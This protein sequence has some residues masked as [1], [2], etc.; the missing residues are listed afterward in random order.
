MQIK[1]ID[2]AAARARAAPAPQ[3]CSNVFSC[4]VQDPG[5]VVASFNATRGTIEN[6]EEAII[7]TSAV[8]VGSVVTVGYV[9]VVLGGAESA[10]EEGTGPEVA[11]A[12]RIKERLR[13]F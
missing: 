13:D 11:I 6:A 9:D 10:L 8:V 1:E 4:I 3:R 12:Y 7:G 5:S 2:Q